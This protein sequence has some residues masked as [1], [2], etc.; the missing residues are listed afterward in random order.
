M[1]PEELTKLTEEELMKEEK[2]QKD[3]L[4][5]L[6]FAIGLL[7]GVAVAVTVIKGFTVST[8]LPL[9][10]IPILFLIQKNYKDVQSEIES[11]KSQ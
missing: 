10:F 3:Q 8:I 4:K 5:G 2:K 7:I 6:R 1:K 11:R 9:F